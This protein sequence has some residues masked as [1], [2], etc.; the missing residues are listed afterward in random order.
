MSFFQNACKPTGIGG[1]IMVRLMNLG[2]AS[3]A[4]WG[5]SHIN[6]SEDAQ[7]LDI[8]C[9]GGA[10]I[11]KLLEKTP[12]GKVFGIDYSEVSVQQS[13]SVNKAAIKN[14]RCEIIRADAEKLPFEEDAFHCITAF[15]TVYFWK[16]LDKCF[17][18]VHRVLKTG[19]KFLICN[20][21]DGEI[22][23]KWTDR[24]E[25]MQV[26]NGETLVHH[27]KK[28]GF[29]SIETD[30]NEKGWLCIVAEK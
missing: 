20:E 22:E 17:Q 23:Q 5:F 7:V 24:I 4:N 8:G 30:A 25:G 21:L 6:I 26:Y 16:D 13:Q 11:K 18:Q 1:K 29:I 27:L 19:G 3:M 15:E 28:V 9:G 10:N 14:G 2:H 12:Q